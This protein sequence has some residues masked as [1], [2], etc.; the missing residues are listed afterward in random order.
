MANVSYLS[1][2]AAT[3]KR[4]AVAAAVDRIG[5]YDGRKRKSPY[6]PTRGV[7]M[8][9][10]RGMGA[11]IQPVGP[12]V[13]LSPVAPPPGA[14]TMLGRSP[15]APISPAAATF[16]AGANPAP[17]GG[18]SG[19]GGGRDP[20]NAFGPAGLGARGFDPAALVAILRRLLASRAMGPGG[21]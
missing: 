2:Y 16:G 5:P 10:M 3:P 8:Q 13:P 20:R 21:F 1:N 15:V 18:F 11:D 12:P 14:G 6:A 19:I 17:I 9:A 4:R 7:P